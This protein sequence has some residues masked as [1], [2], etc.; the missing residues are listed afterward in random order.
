MKKIVI[1]LALLCAAHLSAQSV[2]QQF[3]VVSRGV[4]TVS[5]MDLP[6]P[7]AEGS[8]LIAMPYEFTPGVKVVSVTDNAPAGGNTYKQVPGSV[9]SCDGALLDLWYCEKCNPGVTEL[10]FHLSGHTQMSLNGFLEV[11]GLETTSVLDGEGVHVNDGTRASDGTELGPKITTSANDFIVARYHSAP[12]PRPTAATAP[13]T[14]RPSYAYL[15]N[16]SP[17]AY[18]PTLTGKG[19]G[20]YCMGVAAFKNAASAPVT[21]Q[22]SQ[23]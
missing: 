20:K 13:W 7:T 9:A 14:F 12:E 8:T 6:G 3:V 17:G 4:G 23:K 16:S 18:Q 5:D 1:M 21:A 15:S 22:P 2:L 11:S 10:K 19:T